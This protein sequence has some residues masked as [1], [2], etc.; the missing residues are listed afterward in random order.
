MKDN[1]GFVLVTVMLFLSILSLL[2]FSVLEV[3]LL[4]NKM[5]VFYQDKINSFYIAEEYLLQAER[6]ILDG[7]LITNAN[8]E[9]ND[10]NSGICGVSF[11]RLNARADCRGVKSI[12]RSTLAKVGDI[13]NCNPKP[14]IVSGRQ[15]FW[16]EV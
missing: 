2:A 8:I 13:G 1:C 16:I 14:D 15:S 6:Q 9:I 10:I 5:S 11:Y 4:E 7:K 3:C 12:L